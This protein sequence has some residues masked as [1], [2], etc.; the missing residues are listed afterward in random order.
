MRKG[1]AFSS[2]FCFRR[3]EWNINSRVGMQSVCPLSTSIMTDR[4]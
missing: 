1:D 3:A 2:F 4:E